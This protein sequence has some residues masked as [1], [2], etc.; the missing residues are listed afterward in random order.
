MMPVRVDGRLAYRRALH[1]G[2]LLR[3]PGR[4]RAR[5]ESSSH[6]QARALVDE[7]RGG[8][9]DGSSKGGY[10][11]TGT[12]GGH[13]GTERNGTDRNGSERIGSGALVPKRF[14]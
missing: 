8:G 4:D 1:D 3:G 7:F 13:T 5:V 9:Y 2:S 12:S 14:L 11:A 6:S 10:L